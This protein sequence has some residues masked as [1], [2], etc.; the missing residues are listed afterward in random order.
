[1]KCMLA[2]YVYIQCLGVARCCVYDSN[3][4]DVTLLQLRTVLGKLRPEE[5]ATLLV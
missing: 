1:M 5:N 4:C 2:M 3:L